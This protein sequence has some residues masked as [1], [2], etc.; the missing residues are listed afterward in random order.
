M[1]SM[2]QQTKKTKFKNLDRKMMIYLDP[3]LLLGWTFAV[4]A[5]RDDTLTSINHTTYY[6]IDREN[7]NKTGL[8]HPRTPCDRIP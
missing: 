8:S 4:F 5:G 7:V 2:V 3:L 1:I 6:D